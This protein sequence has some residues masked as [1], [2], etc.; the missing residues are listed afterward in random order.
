MIIF[1]LAVNK[2]FFNKKIWTNSGSSIQLGARKWRISGGYHNSV[3]F[4]LKQ[5]IVVFVRP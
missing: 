1:R 3:A 4:E 5:N 2:L